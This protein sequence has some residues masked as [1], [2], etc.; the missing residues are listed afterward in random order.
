MLRIAITGGI[1]C[2]KSAVASIISD[3]GFPVCEA[4]DLA[5]KAIMPGS[6]PYEE[7]CAEFGS[8]ILDQNGEI[9]RNRL[10]NIVFSDPEKLDS[11]NKIVH[12]DVMQSWSRW[13]DD[14]EKDGKCKAAAV[15]IP[16]L[17][18][19][20]HQEHWDLV[21]CIASSK[22]VQLER[23][24]DRGLSLEEAEKRISA[25]LSVIEKMKL[26]DFVIVND[27]EKSILVRQTEKV[28]ENVIGR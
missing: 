13:L 17:Y 4:D 15:V 14:L 11:L 5:H 23:L 18:E 24:K 2:G 28:L 12:P 26:A 9:D 1:A 6:G 21:L 7:I 27:T 16:L 19:I 10:G 22:A 25:Q 8:D 3:S 20:E